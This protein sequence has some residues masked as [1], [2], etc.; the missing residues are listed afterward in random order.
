MD[1]E[2]GHMGGPKKFLFV[3]Y[4]GFIGD[5]AWI[6]TKEGHQVKYFIE[7]MDAR[8]IA[9]GFVEKSEDWQADVEWADVIVFD[10]VLGQVD[11]NRKANAHVATAAAEDGRVHADCLALHVDQRTA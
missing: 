9:D 1:Q 6:L 4:D 2:N 8:D 5:I 11:G 7:S 10:D 3:S